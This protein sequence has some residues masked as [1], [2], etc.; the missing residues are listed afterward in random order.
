MISVPTVIGPA[1]PTGATGA[2]GPQGDTGQRG[3]V[4]YSGVGD[5]GYIPG[6]M[7]GDM[8][9]DE[10]SGNVWRF[11]GDMWLRGQFA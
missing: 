1:G 3:S 11:D 7:V 5:P 4:W 2:E 10:A 8:Y 6:Q 9:L